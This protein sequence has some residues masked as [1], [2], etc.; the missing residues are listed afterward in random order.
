[1]EVGGKE[2]YA[3][4]RNKES[5]GAHKKQ[6]IGRFWWRTESQ[7]PHEYNHREAAL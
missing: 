2:D 4:E 5:K 1:V 6:N 7:R 3:K